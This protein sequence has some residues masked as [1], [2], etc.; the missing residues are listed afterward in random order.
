MLRRVLQI[1]LS[2]VLLF[3]VIVLCLGVPVCYALTGVWI[4]WDDSK[5]K[6]F[7]EGL[8]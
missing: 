7:L 8:K 5:A 6:E 3:I 4:K 2:P 1:V